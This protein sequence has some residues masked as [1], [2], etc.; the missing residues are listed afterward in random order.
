M[1]ISPGHK[2]IEHELVQDEYMRT[3]EQIFWLESLDKSRHENFQQIFRETKSDKMQKLRWEINFLERGM[4]RVKTRL[5]KIEQDPFLNTYSTTYRY[6]TKT[7]DKAR[8]PQLSRRG[9]IPRIYNTGTWCTDRAK[10]YDRKT[11]Q[12]IYLNIKTI[13][14]RK[15]SGY[16]MQLSH[17]T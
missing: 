6:E 14:R 7:I 17:R 3:L 9:P 13:A 10:L 16:K 15:K 4:Q 11:N 12:D 5:S 2:L 8:I 1:E